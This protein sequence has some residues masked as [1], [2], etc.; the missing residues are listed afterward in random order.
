MKKSKRVFSFLMAMLM[1]F[2]TFSFLAS[3]KAP[4]KDSALTIYDDLDRPTFTFD[5][6]SS[7]LLDYIDKYLA[8]N[9]TVL[10][11]GVLGSL[12]LTSVD[13]IL[14]DLSGAGSLTPLVFDT[15]DDMRGL[16]NKS[17]QTYRRTSTP[18]ATADT[19]VIYSIIQYVNDNKDEFV[20]FI[21]GSFDWGI[22]ASNETL[23]ETK[24]FNVNQ[25]L[26]ELLFKQAYPGTVVPK[27]VNET[28]DNMIQQIIVNF[29]TGSNFPQL[30]GSVNLNSETG[31][32]Y[33][34]LEN[35]LQDGYNLVLVPMLNKDLK[36]AVREFC[37]VVYDDPAAYPNGDESNLN[38]YA[39]IFDIDFVVPVHTFAAGT[40]LVSDLNSIF[41]EIV[42]A[43]LKS[44][45]GW[46][47]GG[48]SH[49]LENLASVAKA[50]LK[51]TDSKIF[52]EYVSRASDAEIDAMNNQQLFSYLLRSFLNST[53]GTMNIPAAADTLIEVVWY[54][55]KEVLAEK[56]PKINY[57]AIPQTLDSILYMLADLA[58]Y[59]INQTVDMNPAFGTTPGTGLLLYGQGFDNTLTSVMA[60]VKTN[61]GGLLNLSLTG[62]DGWADLNTLVTAVIPANWINGFTN[63]KTLVKTQVLQSVLD[64]NT[65]T[66]FALFDHVAG[67]DLSSKTIKKVLLESI[68][69][70]INIIFPGAVL[71]TYT[72]FDQI[73][74]NTQLKGTAER[75][76]EQLNSR[77]TSIIPVLLPLVNRAIGASAPEGYKNLTI[78]LPKQ[79]SAATVFTIR[80]VSTGVNTG[81]TNKAGVFTQDS[82][83][84]IKIASI[85][86]NISAITPTNLVGTIINGG[87]SVNCMLSGTFAANQVLMVTLT[88]DIYTE[89]GTKLTSNSLTA[90]AF[91]YISTVIDDGTNY[92]TL[93]PNTL[94]T[95]TLKYKNVYCNQDYNLAILALQD[96]FIIQR[97]TTNDSVNSLAATVSRTF[98]SVNATLIA[99]GVTAAPWAGNF[100]TT[101]DGGFWSIPAF[102]VDPAA[103]RPDD[104]AYR[105]N[106]SYSATKTDLL[107]T[108]ETF[109]VTNYVVFYND[110]GLPALL[111]A[112]LNAK[113]DP[114]NYS[115]PD[116]WNEYIFALKNAIGVT[117]RPK[118]AS[119]FMTTIA[120][121]YED[122][123]QMLND[124]VTA[125]EAT[126]IT[127]PPFALQTALDSIEPSNAGLSY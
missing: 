72:T 84:K 30:T 20:K 64:I 80:N 113:R 28:A 109:A 66:L 29:I 69:K 10:D 7:M 43:I 123:V 79:I 3:A 11:L 127:S 47:A 89:L 35:L 116:A 102:T 106:F 124:A 42:N 48:N 119:T 93:D 111:S 82:L 125:L 105:S 104:G 62:T 118:T 107:S 40:T 61:Y 6:C 71:T 121:A 58:V 87:E 97:A 15:V 49:V 65:T 55:L 12:N 115:D 54:A 8:E 81:A 34:F 92:T 19:N 59:F 76:A 78:T 39:A 17:I 16:N 90:M 53:V 101:F 31:T 67:N 13:N 112:E 23:N 24:N 68:A 98:P 103:T 63:V 45:S 4:Y 44:Y 25:T 33:D 83:Y 108:P 50:V 70:V 56:V 75:L 26:K 94:N 74:D 51:Q 60:W 36:R 9:S 88:Y 21:D 114:A 110:F 14:N 22:A 91:S 120:P 37:G 117:Y 27:P 96:Q 122:A 99:N 38:E 2:S 100:T 126:E 77:S 86:T 18:A 41:A 52:A 85:K 1:L 57:S 73:I 32:A 46:V 95:H 5:Q